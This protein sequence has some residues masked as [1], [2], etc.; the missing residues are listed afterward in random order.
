MV[1]WHWATLWC[2]RVA[3]TTMSY[4]H[5]KANPNRKKLDLPLRIGSANLDVVIIS[6]TKNKDTFPWA[7]IFNEAFSDH[8]QHDALTNGRIT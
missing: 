6:E 4:F 5:V 7:Q 3:V 2:E 8:Y 1:P